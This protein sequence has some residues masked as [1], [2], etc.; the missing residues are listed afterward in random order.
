[1]KNKKHDWFDSF[2]L[3]YEEKK[4]SFGYQHF[5]K[6]EKSN[7]R[8]NVNKQFPKILVLPCLLV[9][10]IEMPSVIKIAISSTG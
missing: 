7:F 4:V 5:F 2:W 8:R 10:L 3:Q 9:N 1:M 6:A